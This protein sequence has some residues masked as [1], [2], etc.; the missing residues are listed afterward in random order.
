MQKE[1]SLLDFL[2]TSST[3]FSKKYQLVL[4]ICTKVVSK[5]FYPYYHSNVDFK[6]C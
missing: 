5:C 2:T 4:K 1:D 6:K 3:K